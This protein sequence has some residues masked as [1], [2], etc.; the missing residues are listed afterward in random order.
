M[1]NLSEPTASLETK[2]DKE[3]EDRLE[4][5]WTRMLAYIRQHCNNGVLTS[6]GEGGY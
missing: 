2:H 5:L 4:D 6:V 3:N 1:T